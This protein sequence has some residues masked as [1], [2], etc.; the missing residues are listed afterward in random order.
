MIIDEDGEVISIDEEDFKRAIK[1]PY[2]KRIHRSKTFFLDETIIKRFDELA[3]E[4]GSYR[5]EYITKV[6]LSYLNQV[7][8]QK[9]EKRQ[10]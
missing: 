3:E 10:L 2:A 5:D 7:E 4:K 1:N 9:I 6:L 8:K